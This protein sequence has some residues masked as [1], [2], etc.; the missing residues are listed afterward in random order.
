MARYNHYFSSFISGEIAPEAYGI[1]DSEVYQKSAELI[2]NFIVQKFGGLERRPGTIYADEAATT[3]NVRL[4]PFFHP[5][6][7]TFYMLEFS[8]LKFRVYKEGVL[9][10]APYEVTTPYTAAEVKEIDFDQT[11]SELYITHENHYPQRVT[12]QGD[13]SWTIEDVPFECTPMYPL[14]DPIYGRT[15]DTGN[16]STTFS[17]SGT[18]L[19]SN[20]DIF[21]SDDVGKYIR[22][23]SFVIDPVEEA[24][25]TLS[26]TQT[27]TDVKTLD[28]A[29]ATVSFEGNTVDVVNQ[30]VNKIQTSP[31][32][33][34]YQDI[35]SQRAVKSKQWQNLPSQQYIS[36]PDQFVKLPATTTTT[37]TTPYSTITTT[38]SRTYSGATSGTAITS[39]TN[40][41]TAAASDYTAYSDSTYSAL[42]IILTDEDLTY[43]VEIPYAGITTQ[44]SGSALTAETTNVTGNVEEKWGLIKITAFT[45]ARNVTFSTER[46]LSTTSLHSSQQWQFSR[47]GNTGSFPKKVTFNEGRCIFGN[48]ADGNNVISGSKSNSITDFEPGE[49]DQGTVTAATAFDFKLTEL[50]DIKWLQPSQRLIIGDV[51]GVY[52]ITGGNVGINAVQPP[53]FRKI[54]DSKCTDLKPI[55][56]ES[57]TFYVHQNGKKVAALDYRQGEFSGFQYRDASIFAEH[58]LTDGI[59][60]WT[61]KDGLIWAITTNGLLRGFTFNEQFGVNAWHRH[62]LTNGAASSIATSGD[63]VYFAME[64]TIN[65]SDVQYIEYLSPSIQ[66]KDQDDTICVDCAF[67]YD[68]TSTSTISGLSHLEGEEV[69]IL[70]D[71][72]SATNATVSSGEISLTLAAS[73][74][75]LG[76]PYVSE[77]RTVEIMQGNRRGSRES[78]RARINKV[79]VKLHETSGGKIGV[80]DSTEEIL[81]FNENQIW[82]QGPSRFSGTQVRKINSGSTFNPHI[83]V[84]SDRALPISILGISAD[85]SITET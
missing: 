66:S 15:K 34:S 72:A 55:F 60:N 13:T 17:I 49:G 3:G 6:S 25:A 62:T 65:S 67:T 47:F 71:G 41:Y 69:E 32:S 28:G 26:T 45:N 81:L 24:N 78:V 40:T 23:K 30:I 74:V 19:T 21:T 22:I 33:T 48:F 68:S 42:G 52:S 59:V 2:D 5:S 8:N 53:I 27:T 10:G 1:S 73:T 54:A 79:G 44:Y 51:N 76:I 20:N 43:D 31:G 7:G 37:R 11:G 38:V 36:I 85:L 80:A 9:L 16:S 77:L 58:L 56:L 63:K 12:R 50:Q 39:G 46:A 29:S 57:T 18:T 4:V 70:A 84:K 35:T 64:R 75:Q 61:F 82:G 14:D 83:T